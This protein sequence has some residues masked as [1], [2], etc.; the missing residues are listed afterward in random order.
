MST[1]FKNS[2]F[3]ITIMTNRAMIQETKLEY[4]DALLVR[5]LWDSR[6]KDWEL[7]ETRFAPKVEIPFKLISLCQ[8][9]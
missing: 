4:I 2:L 3:H 8:F 9:C 6:F 7:W 1:K 5:E